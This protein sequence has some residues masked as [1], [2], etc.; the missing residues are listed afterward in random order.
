MLRWYAYL[1]GDGDLLWTDTTTGESWDRILE[2]EAIDISQLGDTVV[3][4]LE[5]R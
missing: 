3:V 5:R 4:L 2:T 1:T